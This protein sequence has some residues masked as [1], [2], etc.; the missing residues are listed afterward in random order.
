[1][2]QAAAPHAAPSA[3]VSAAVAAMYEVICSECGGVARVPF[4]PRMDRPVYCSTCFD[5]QRSARW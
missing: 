4:Q 1:M 3:R 2:S 5:Q